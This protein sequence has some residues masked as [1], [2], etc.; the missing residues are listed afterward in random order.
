M[1]NVR[2]DRQRSPRSEPNRSEKQ[3]HKGSDD[4]ESYS[5]SG[6][7]SSEPYVLYSI[8][9]S[10]TLNSIERDSL[11]SIV[12]ESYSVRDQFELQTLYCI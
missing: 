6:I 7:V 4:S 5:D 2:S 1:P 8:K 11:Y 12:A 10:Y 9:V 3:R